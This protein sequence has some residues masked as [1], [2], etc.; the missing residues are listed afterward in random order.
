MTPSSAVRACALWVCLLSACGGAQGTDGSATT[1]P[2]RAAEPVELALRT[3]AGAFIDLGDLRG[4]PV[5]LFVF[6]T[7]DAVSQAAARPLARFQ[8]T[9]AAD[10]HVVGVAVQPNAS[11]LVGPWADALG[12]T[13]TVAYEPEPKIL[14]GDT[15]LGEIA[16]VPSYIVL[17]RDGVV[18]ARYVGFASENK[19]ER[20]LEAASAH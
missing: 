7:F 5:V 17:D 19:L 18:V 16:G 11:E 13:F 8:R 14:A 3:P 10:T 20:L 9:H 4:E 1:A 15:A 6:A 12:V 2:S